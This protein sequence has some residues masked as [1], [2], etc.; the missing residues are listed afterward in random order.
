MHVH[1]CVYVYAYVY[2]ITTSK[3]TCTD[4]RKVINWNMFTIRYIS[5]NS[6]LQLKE[7]YKL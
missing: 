4:V 7:L 5:V 3:V 6:L 2:V 1:V